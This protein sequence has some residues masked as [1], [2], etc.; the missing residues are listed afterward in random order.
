[1]RVIGTAGHVDHGKSTLVRALTGINPDRLAEEQR[2]E[3]TIDLG[4]AWMKLP[5]GEVV[6]IVD[7]PGHIDF[8]EN[9]LAGVGG[10]DLVLFVVAADEGI[11]PQTREHLAIIDLLEVKRGVIVLTK[12]DTVDDPDW[13]QL[14]QDEIR[15]TVV[16]TVLADAPIL[17]VSAKNGSG[18]DALI[19]ELARLVELCPEKHDDHRARLP[20]DRVFS[21]TGFGTIVTGT[22]LDGVLKTGQEMII[23]PAGLQ[24]RIRGLQTHK[25]KVDLAYPGSRVAVNLSNL[26][27]QQLKRGDILAVPGVYKTT[28]RFNA[29][30]RLLKDISQPIKHNDTVKL[31]ISTQEVVSRVRLLG[32]EEINPGESGWL[33]LELKQ[34]IVAYTGDRFI[35]RRPSPGETLGGGAIL[36]SELRF[37]QKRFD[38]KVIQQLEALW[39]G[40]P[41]DIV[42]QKCLRE[43]ITTKTDLQ[44]K[45]ALAAE[46]FE[47]ALNQLLDEKSVMDLSIDEGG[48]NHYLIPFVEFSNIKQMILSHLK[49]YHEENPERKGA[50][51]SDLMKSLKAHRNLISAAVEKM[52]EE[53]DVM[54]DGMLI[55]LPSHRVTI[56]EKMARQIEQLKKIMDRAPFSPPSRLELEKEL[57]KRA[58]DAFI[59]LEYLIPLTSD[60]VLSSTTYSKVLERTKQ[61]IHENGNISV[62]QLRDLIGTSRK[63][64]VAFLEFL[65]NE[66]ITIRQGDFR[67]LSAG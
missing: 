14:I 23:L 16:G 38:A 3:M 60:I 39:V 22:L 54:G 29:H 37:R 52:R 36:E 49:G 51:V 30:V 56:D 47:S 35:M 48:R 61:F 67:K 27:T 43:K 55:W 15:K 18:L 11:M 19:T 58:V 4:F 33:Q 31:F 21:M 10:I 6:G 17:P 2:R 46:V 42:Y 20:I 62:A 32:S 59:D 25:Q 9:M 7:V 28:K 57:G 66:K 1:M 24:A 45:S 12:T 8:I 63:Y 13:L 26:N 40:D 44:Q 65:D 34:P 50:A 64:A 53:G 5:N 41:K